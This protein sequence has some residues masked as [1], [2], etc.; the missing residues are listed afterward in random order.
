MSFF[1]KLRENVDSLFEGS[2]H[3]ADSVATLPFSEVIGGPIGVILVTAATYKAL[4]T[5]SD[6]LRSGNPRGAYKKALLGASEATEAIPHFIP[7]LKIVMTPEES[8]LLSKSVAESII[9]G[10]QTKATEVFSE[11]FVQKAKGAEYSL[12]QEAF[13]KSV[14]LGM[15][16]FLKGTAL[17]THN[18]A[19]GYL[20]D[21]VDIQ[22]TYENMG[23]DVYAL[24][25]R[26][27]FSAKNTFGLIYQYRQIDRGLSEAFKGVN[28]VYTSAVSIRKNIFEQARETGKSIGNITSSAAKSALEEGAQT[29]KKLEGGFKSLFAGKNG[30]DEIQP[31]K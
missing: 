25:S 5:A 11:F 17:A 30:N 27:D 22:R 18:P 6:E 20:A 26:G 9:I 3:T 23:K 8:A 16:H 12:S 14:G 24:F 29:F 4:T 31:G 15:K 2:K 1:I 13:G 21:K 10:D 28:Q 19:L 7:G